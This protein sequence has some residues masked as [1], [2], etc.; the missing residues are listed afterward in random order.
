MLPPRKS[1][2]VAKVKWSFVGHTPELSDS[3]GFGTGGVADVNVV[4]VPFGH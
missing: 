2:S 1:P 4:K 3:D